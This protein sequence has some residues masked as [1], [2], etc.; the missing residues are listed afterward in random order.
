MEKIIGEKKKKIRAARKKYQERNQGEKKKLGS[1]ST[2][3]GVCMVARLPGAA[4]LSTRRQ[5]PMGCLWVCLAGDKVG[6]CTQPSARVKAGRRACPPLW[7]ALC[8]GWTRRAGRATQL[9]ISSPCMPCSQ[10]HEQGKWETR[11]MHCVCPSV[12][13]GKRGHALILT[14]QFLAPVQISTWAS[15]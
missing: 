11:W 15:R 2:S 5:E 13:G 8:R 7:H 4:T 14:W 3:E 6:G 12:R 1:N 10:P 9:W